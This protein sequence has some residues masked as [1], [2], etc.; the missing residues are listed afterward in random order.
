MTINILPQRPIETKPGLT[1]QSDDAHSKAEFRLVGAAVRFGVLVTLS[2]GRAGSRG[3]IMID[4]PAGKQFDPELHCL[5]VT[6]P[7]AETGPFRLAPWS[8]VVASAYRDLM[9][10]GPRVQDCPDDCPCRGD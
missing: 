1:S 3:E 6:Q 5:V 8:T 7:D 4:A 9:E 2:R 10:Y